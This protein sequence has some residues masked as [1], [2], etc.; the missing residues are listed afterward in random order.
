M[1]EST[2]IDQQGENRTIC[3]MEI[4]QHGRRLSKGITYIK[5]AYVKQQ[6]KDGELITD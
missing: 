6:R 5:Q 2:I 4:R 1:A 3:G